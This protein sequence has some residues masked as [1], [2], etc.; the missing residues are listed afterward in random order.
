M[1]LT[2]LR[3]TV[4]RNQ[5]VSKCPHKILSPTYL[6]GQDIC[7]RHAIQNKPHQHRPAV[8]TEIGE[9]RACP[10]HPG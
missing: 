5:L 10:N 2:E 8:E 3:E 4:S 9:S 7:Y 6:N 1:Y